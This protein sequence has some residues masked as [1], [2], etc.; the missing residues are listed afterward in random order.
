M[1]ELIETWSKSSEDEDSMTDGHSW[2]WREMIRAADLPDLS[3]A[4]VLDV[5][6]NQGGFLRLLYD[7]RP[8]RSAVGIDLARQAVALAEERAGNR[9][10]TYQ[11]GTLLADAGHG[12]DVAFSHEVIYLIDDLG[13][14][15]SQIAGVLKPGGRYFAVTCCHSDSPLWEKWRPHLQDLSNLPVPDHSVA[16]IAGAFRKARFE[17]AVS[18][19]LANAFIPLEA[20]GAYCPSDLDTLELYTR[21][22][23]LFRFTQPDRSTR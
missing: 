5:G 15:A 9:P 20:P 17:V 21:W 16:D 11:T 22:K 1:A 10:I 19:F 4:R 18:R 12:F 3:N 2:I 14:H 7:L 13:D 23:L 8:F 6:C